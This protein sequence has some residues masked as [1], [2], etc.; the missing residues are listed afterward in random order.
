MPTHGKETILVVDDAEAVRKMVCAVLSQN[1]YVCVE[2]SDGQEAL[3]RLNNEA[4]QLVL[5]DMVMPG[6][7]GAELAS[8]L[9][10]ERPDVRIMF[11]SGYSDHPV[12]HAVQRVPTLF[13]EK[14]FTTGALMSKIRQALDEPWEGMT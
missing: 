11:M 14:P 8:R 12:V 1:G 13:L 2:A 3:L 10:R 5:T 6:M 7:G 9:A 4:V